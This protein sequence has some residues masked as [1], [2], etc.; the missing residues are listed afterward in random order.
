MPADTSPLERRAATGV[1]IVFF[2]AGYP[3]S[4]LGRAGTRSRREKD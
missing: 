4:G 2:I 3:L 1:T